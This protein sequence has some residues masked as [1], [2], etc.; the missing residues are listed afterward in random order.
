MTAPQFPWD[1]LGSV[2][3]FLAFP[4]HNMLKVS[5]DIVL[6]KQDPLDL[7]CAI[8]LHYGDYVSVLSPRVSLMTYVGLILVS[9]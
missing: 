6:H 4:T 9:W 3:Y 1:H 7:P 8:S 2:A 5:Y